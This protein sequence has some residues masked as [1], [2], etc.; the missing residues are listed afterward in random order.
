MKPATASSILKKQVFFP[1]KSGYVCTL[2]I[3]WTNK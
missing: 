2:M 1:A 3:D